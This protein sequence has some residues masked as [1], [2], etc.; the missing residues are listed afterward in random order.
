MRELSEEN[1]RITKEV[2]TKAIALSNELIEYMQS[3]NADIRV[4]VLAAGIT[5]S[6][7]S[8]VLGAT[9]PATIDVIRMF[10]KNA[11]AAEKAKNL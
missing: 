7:G 8:M 5:Y 3:K 10:Y 2:S 6:K 11:E 1:L 9:L 4:A